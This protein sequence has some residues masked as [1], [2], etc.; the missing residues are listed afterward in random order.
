MLHL[1]RGDRER[2]FASL[3]EALAWARKSGSVTL[4]NGWQTALA[5]VLQD[6]PDDANA[7]GTYRRMISQCRTDDD[8]ANL[9]IVLEALA[10]HFAHNERFEPAAV[11]FAALER[12]DRA[13]LDFEAARA[14][15]LERLAREPELP[16]WQARGLA[17]LRGD[18]VDYALGQLESPESSLDM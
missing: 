6:A 4:L 16:Q 13:S 11:L 15:A 17:L 12:A 9:W 5:Y 18:V 10:V 2:A 3:E 7:R 14:P 1:T 8:W